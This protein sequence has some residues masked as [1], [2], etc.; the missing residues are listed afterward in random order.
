[1]KS[2]RFNNKHLLRIDKGEELV[3]ALVEFCESNSI[4]LANVSALGAA[5][6]IVVGLFDG[7]SKEYACH[8]F[9][10][11]FEITN[12]TGTITTMN[13]N[14]YPHLHITFSDK[15]CHAFGG[16]LNRCVISA[17]CEMILDIVGGSVDREYA[18]G[19]GLNLLKL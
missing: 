8:E 11:M 18:P 2:T 3:A 9:S 19:V 16:H 13:G 17:T 4:T 15:N 6:E 12:I 5:S 7:H 14:V 1:M 10:G